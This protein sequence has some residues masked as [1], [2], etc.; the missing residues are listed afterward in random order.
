M[1]KRLPDPGDA[2]ALP[3]DRPGTVGMTTTAAQTR[4]L[5]AP[6]RAGID[7]TLFMTS[8]AGNNV[9]TVS[10]TGG[11]NYTGHNTITFTSTGESVTLRSIHQGA[12]GLRWQVVFNDINSAHDDQT[13]GLTTV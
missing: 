1:E 11:I 10:G 4:T 6:A 8:A 2:G 13:T 7:L 3:A 5:A 9:I 12:N